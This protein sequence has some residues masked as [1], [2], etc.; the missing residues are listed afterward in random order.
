MTIWQIS[1]QILTSAGGRGG[2]SHEQS[3]ILSDMW[4]LDLITMTWTEITGKD[5]P[6]P[7]ARFLH[8][9]DMFLPPKDD[10]KSV[11]S[12]PKPAA[13]PGKGRA[14]ALSTEEQPTELDIP[15]GSAAAS[16][17]DQGEETGADVQSSS[18]LSGALMQDEHQLAGR[19]L[20][21]SQ[22]DSTASHENDPVENSDADND[23]DGNMEKDDEE[24][25]D[26]ST[27]E[28]DNDDDSDDSEEDEQAAE[29]ATEADSEAAAPGLGPSS[30][31]VDKHHHHHKKHHKHDGKHDDDHHN[32]H[33]KKH[34]KHHD[35]KKKHK[36]HHKGRVDPDPAQG[37]YSDAK[38]VVFGGQ[39][40]GGCYLNDAW[41]F[42]PVTSIWR[43]I[44]PIVSDDYKCSGLEITANVQGRS[45]ASAGLFAGLQWLSSRPGL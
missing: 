35:G 32:H 27:D 3:K 8:S 29:A 4:S 39:G 30:S 22:P 40:E 1:S 12:S 10:N 16:V 24:N 20:L 38:L 33:G 7:P 42:D 36:K 14:S 17:G 9:F 11:S 25:G 37:S 44:S 43:Q 2:P 31:D 5:G 6:L 18:A 41:E 21:S 19:K 13:L 15:I 26:D 34:G 23:D 28:D 45:A